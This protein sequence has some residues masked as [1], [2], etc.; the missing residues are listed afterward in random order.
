MPFSSL[1]DPSALARA[2]AA[3]DRAWKEVEPEVEVDDLEQER[4][5]LA[6]IVASLVDMA[7]DEDELAHKAVDRF[8]R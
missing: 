1:K 3:M 4:S 2:S 7:R 6:Y 5:R 8:R